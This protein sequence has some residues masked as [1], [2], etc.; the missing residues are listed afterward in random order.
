MK[1]HALLLTLITLL[2]GYV[3]LSAQ[4]I[5]IGA[6][7]GFSIPNLTSGGTGNPLNNGY[8]SRLGPA[9]GI[10]GEYHFSNLFS[11]SLGLEYSSQG[12]K[13][14]GFQAF[15][16]SAQQAAMLPENTPY[17]YASY[18]SEAKLNYLIVPVLARFNW[19]I[20]RT[21]P[22]KFVAAVGPFAGFLLNAHQV[23][24]G[25]SVIYL[26]AAGQYP[27]SSMQSFDAN[28]N[29]KDQLHTFNMGI[30]GFIGFTYNLTSKNALF[31]EGGG[32]FGF[33]PIQKNS[34]DGKNYTG[35]GVV[36]IGYSY[37]F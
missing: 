19:S 34:S 23:T 37:T 29:I 21:L 3:T 9:F 32:N 24:S 15:S 27:I 26:D 8:S 31:I 1:K 36:T 25:S 33:I 11:I 16:P 5:T 35:A 17:L 13:K 30:N 28:T 18:N 6:K 4:N 12:G 20:C 10:Y 14:K 2:G 22:L 7:G